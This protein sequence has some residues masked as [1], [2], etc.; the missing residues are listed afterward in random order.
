MRAR[1]RSAGLQLRARTSTASSTGRAAA[2]T[3]EAAAS[4]EENEETA[5]TKRVESALY[6]CTP[7]IHSVPLSSRCKRDVLLKLD[8]LQPT[9]SFKD[10]GMASLCTHLRETGARKLISSSGGNAGLACSNAGRVLGMEVQVVVPTTTK[11]L[12]LEKM[13]QHGA[14]VRVHGANW[15]E[16]DELAR[17][18]VEEEEHAEYVHPFEHP[19]L[20]KG[21]STMIDEIVETGTEKPAAV[22]ACVGGG[23]MLCGIYEGLKRNGWADVQVFTAETEGASCFATAMRE[24]KPTQLRAIESIATSLG[25]LQ[26]SNVAFERAQSHPT[27]PFVSTDAEAVQACID[28][29]HDHRVLVEPACGA[30]LAVVYAQRHREALAQIA[31]SGP[32]VVIVCGGSGVN[33]ELLSQWKHQF[34]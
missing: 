12:M 6:A 4:S 26:V 15:N 17:K 23:G 28:F 1:H 16:A 30:G 29:A 9:G 22:V 11:A 25:A 32:L 19:M 13:K 8:A 18:M 5:L 31:A 14:D 24:G 2:S 10:R 34:L 20:W 3:A 21:H 33:L 27:T 7:L